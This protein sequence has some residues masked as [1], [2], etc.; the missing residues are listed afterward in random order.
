MRSTLIKKYYERNR[1]AIVKI[2]N[3]NHSVRIRKLFMKK[4]RR[5]HGE[6]FVVSY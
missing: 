2:I 6:K 5:V 4:E 3:S 1:S